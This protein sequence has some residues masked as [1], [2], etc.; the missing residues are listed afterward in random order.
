[1]L[2]VSFR[3]AGPDGVPGDMVYT[4]S[5]FRPTGGLTLAFA[6]S[7]TMNGETQRHEHGGRGDHQRP[8]D[9]ALWKRKAAT[10]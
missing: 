8:V 9:E 5:D 1:M 6:Q 7:T 4:F 10:P 2:T 3:G